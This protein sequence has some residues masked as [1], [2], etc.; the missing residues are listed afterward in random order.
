MQVPLVKVLGHVWTK[1]R[2]YSN[3]ASPSRDEGMAKAAEDLIENVP[4]AH[5]NERIHSNSL[6]L[7][8]VVAFSQLFQ[9][10]R[11]KFPRNFPKIR[12][13]NINIANICRILTYIKVWLVTLIRHIIQD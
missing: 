1:H 6:N 8:L 13:V 12:W 9:V 7:Y 10:S 4:Q 2:L 11:V 3:V 5:K